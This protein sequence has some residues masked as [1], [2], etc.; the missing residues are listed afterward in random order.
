[1]KFNNLV[2]IILSFLIYSKVKSNYCSAETCRRCCSVTPTGCINNQ[3]N[4]RGKMVSFLSFCSDCDCD[5]E[6]QGCGWKASNFGRIECTS[7]DN[8]RSMDPT[9]NI[10]ISGC[11]QVSYNGDI[12]YT[13]LPSAYGP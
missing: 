5:D 1:M 8:L 3:M 7:C 4:I 12:V 9:T 13:T 2:Y 11:G 10:V 6:G